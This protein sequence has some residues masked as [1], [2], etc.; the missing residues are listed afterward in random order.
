MRRVSCSGCLRT[1]RVATA[2]LATF[3]EHSARPLRVSKAIRSQL[4]IAFALG[5]MDESDKSTAPYGSLIQKFNRWLLSTFSTESVVEGE[6][7]SLRGK[8]LEHLSLVSAPSAIDQIVGM[9]TTTTSTCQACDFV[10]SRDTTIH[11]ID[12]AYPRK[13]GVDLEPG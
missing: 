7:F 4:T 1:Q 5:L 13:V 8:G 9:N 2:K 6:T 11:A 12:L 3:H 10:A